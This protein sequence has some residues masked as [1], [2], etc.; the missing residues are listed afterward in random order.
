MIN[1]PTLKIIKTN[2]TSKDFVDMV[3]LLDKELAIRDGDDHTFYDQFNKLDKIKYAIVL[4]VDEVAIGCGAIKRFDE[5]SMEIKRM[6]VKEDLRGLGY[7][8]IVLTYLENW[9]K[10]LGF[11]KCILETG[12]NQPEAIRLYHKNNYQIVDNY[13][14]Y[15]GVESSICFLKTL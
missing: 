8:S 3:Q 2:N 12:Y 1:M 11:K 15:M 7:A 10:G 14:Q 4:Y 6:Y 9:A 13:G 5:E